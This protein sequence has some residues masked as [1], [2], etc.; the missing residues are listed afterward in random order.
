M[1]ILKHKDF[2]A[3][4][5]DLDGVIT[6]TAAVHAAAWKKLFDEFLE[7]RAAFTNAIFEP[8]EGDSEQ[9][10]VCGLGNKKNKYFL[11]Q[12]HIDGVD[13]YEP[14]VTFI[15]KAKSKGFKCAM[16]SSSKN[17]RTV[18]EEAGLANLFEVRV[19]GLEIERLGFQGLGRRQSSSG[20]IA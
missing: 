10:T 12:L 5:V 14:A 17:C 2:D 8:S 19:D 7:K 20:R 1:K 6:K 15:R 13:L 11:E 3:L 16:V 4:L 18:L 9:E